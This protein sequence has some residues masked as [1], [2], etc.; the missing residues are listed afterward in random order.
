MWRAHVATRG[1]AGGKS[2]LQGV[3]AVRAHTG[4][5]RLGKVMWGLQR[6]R[7]LAQRLGELWWGKPC[8]P[9]V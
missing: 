5:P 9:E 8:A 2:C 4:R 3:A 7:E 6:R 1:A